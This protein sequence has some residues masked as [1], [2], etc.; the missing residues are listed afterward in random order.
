M[1]AMR[2]PA[3]L[4]ML[5]AVGQESHPLAVIMTSVPNLRPVM[6]AIPIH[7]DLAMRIAQEPEPERLVETVRDARSLKIAMMVI[8][9]LA[10][11]ATLIVR[12]RALVRLAATARHVPS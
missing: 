7:V 10:A 11:P 8:P 2:M 12:Q 9:M 4:V 5:T 1:M 3:G 6:T